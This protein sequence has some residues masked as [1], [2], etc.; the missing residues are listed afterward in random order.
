MVY[1]GSITAM[2]QINEGDIQTPGPCH[3][4]WGISHHYLSEVFG[5][6]GCYISCILQANNHVCLYRLWCP[7]YP[8]QSHNVTSNFLQDS[9]WTRSHKKQTEPHWSM[10]LLDS[11]LGS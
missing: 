2:S 7:W 4:Q 9:F 11:D 6:M 1:W 10:G 8:F 5:R 3:L